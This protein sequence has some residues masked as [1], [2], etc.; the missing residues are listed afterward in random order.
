MSA[1]AQSCGRARLAFLL[2]GEPTHAITLNDLVNP[3]PTAN[4]NVGVDTSNQ[5]PNVVM[6]ETQIPGG[7]T[8][9]TGT[10][11]NSRT[12]LTAAHCQNAFS[13]SANTSISFAPIAGPTNLIGTSSFNSNSLFAVPQNDIALI[14]L[15]T[16]V[17]SIAPVTLIG[18]NPITTPGTPLTIVGY[19][20][21]GNGTSGCSNQSDGNR[22]V[23]TTLLGAYAT[24]AGFGL[25][26]KFYRAQFRN[27]V[28]PNQFN[29]FNLTAPV[30][31]LQ[32]GTCGGD[33]GGPL[34]IQTAQGLVEIGELQGTL[35]S[36]NGK[37]GEIDNWTPINLFLTWIAQNNP[38]REVT[39]AAG[40]FNW[41]NPAAWRDSAQDELQSEGL[42]NGVPNNRVISYTAGARYYDVTLSNPGTITLDM[43]PT[44]DTLAI[45]GVQSQLTLPA[46]F[47][48]T[49]VLTPRC[50]PARSP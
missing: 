39:A 36:V 3:N 35:V 24:P 16:P 19:G 49:T 6:V 40:N 15:A 9:C 12:I 28:N 14:S 38:L 25:T 4:P 21:F 27:P 46:P 26:Q 23:A 44:I 34:F 7:V 50:P 20:D 32:G 45:A 11:I 33:S 31:A 22:R 2:A 8:I 41:S 10:L 43:N 17:T 13:S 29:D 1:T 30:P 18:P 48:L 5:F 42:V 37:Y 47:T